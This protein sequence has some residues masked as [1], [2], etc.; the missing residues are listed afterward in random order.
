MVAAR[1]PAGAAGAI[2][3]A[4]VQEVARQ[5]RAQAPAVKFCGL[6]STRDVEAINALKPNY[7]GFVFFEKSKRC[8]TPSV[9]QELRALLDE[10]ITT[11]GVFVDAPLETVVALYNAGSIA[12]AQLHGQESEA[13]IA[14]LRTAA[15][16]LVIWKAFVAKTLGDI[17]AANASS[18]DFV[19]VDGG[20]GDGRTFQWDLLNSIERPY[21]LA[22][23]LNCENVA[24]A[25]A[26]LTPAV[27]DVSSGIEQDGTSMPPRKDVHKMK[28][29][30]AEVAACTKAFATTA[31]DGAHAAGTA[32]QPEGYC[33]QCWR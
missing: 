26:Q 1:I 32:Q 10:A 9:A 14:T 2:A 23:G 17:E 16:G 6:A 29:F 7:V 27:I 8:I 33:Y 3:Q 20:M 5:A 13:Y 21:A 4:Q 28:T 15:P 31:D 18:A 25:L 12:V 11:V 30:L 24:N 22:G 19:L